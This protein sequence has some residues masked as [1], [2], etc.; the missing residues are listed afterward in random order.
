MKEK[1]VEFVG[2]DDRLL[3]R[4]RKSTNWSEEEL[5]EVFVAYKQFIEL[6]VILKDWNALLLS[7]SLM[8]DQIWHLHV[9]DTKVYSRACLQLCDEIIHHD[10]DGDVDE[11]KRKLRVQR[12][13]ETFMDHFGYPCKGKMWYFE[14]SEFMNHFLYNGCISSKL[15]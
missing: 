5:S 4:V 10:P 6:K 13:K 2:V 3:K 14:N 9:L 7:P 1:L 15:K 8:V 12:T 11:G